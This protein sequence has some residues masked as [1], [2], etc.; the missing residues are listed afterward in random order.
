[1][2]IENQ[3]NLNKVDLESNLTPKFET[4]TQSSNWKASIRKTDQSKYSNRYET[5]YTDDDDGTNLVIHTI[6]VPRQTA[7]PR[8]TKFLTKSER[9]M[10]KRKRIRKF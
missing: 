7:V 1:M 5:L 3:N 6:V 2:L 9:V 4:G 10:Y 8:L